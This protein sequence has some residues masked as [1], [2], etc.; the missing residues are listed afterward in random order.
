MSYDQYYHLGLAFEFMPHNGAYILRTDRHGLVWH[1]TY[2]E[3]EWTAEIKDHPPYHCGLKMNIDWK[4]TMSPT[5]HAAKELA[6]K[7]HSMQG[8]F[9][10]ATAVCSLYH[11]EQCIIDHLDAMDEVPH[12]TIIALDAFFR[13]IDDP[14]PRM[15]KYMAYLSASE[16]LRGCGDAERSLRALHTLDVHGLV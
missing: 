8:D 5:A 7:H 14:G 16:E 9:R 15:V 1:G 11:H 10:R 12:T 2:N 6:R 13:Q 4:K 3:N